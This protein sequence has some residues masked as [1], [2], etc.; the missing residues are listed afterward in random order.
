[1]NDAPEMKAALSLQEKRAFL[2]QRLRDEATRIK[3][4]HPLSYGQRALWFLHQ[5]AQ[6]STAYNVALTMR[7]G[8]RLDISA[9]RTAFETLVARHAA[10]RTTFSEQNGKPVQVIHGYREIYFEEFDASG[11]TEEGLHRRVTEM[12]RRP[13]DLEQGP[14][15]RVSLF[16]HGPKDY[17]LLI[18]AHHI[19]S[20]GWSLWLLMLELLSLYPSQKIGRTLTLPPLP[21]QYQDFV[22]WQAELLAGPEGERLWDYWRQRLSGKLP[23]LHLPTDR[24]R[25][26]MQTNNGAVVTFVLPAILTEELKEQAQ[27]SG[28]TLYMILLAA[29]QVLLHRY[30]GE[31][32]ILVGSP[33]AGRDRGEFEG[34]FGYFVNP[35]ALRANLEGNPTFLAFLDQVRQ[36]A[37]EGLAHQNYPFPL[38]VE[39]LKPVRDANRFPIFQVIFALHKPHQDEE[40]SIFWSG[41]EDEN[42]SVERDGL[43][44]TPFKIV[45]QEGLYDLVVELVEERQLLFGSFKY[46]TDLFKARTITRMA[47]HFRRLLEG[48]VAQ[49][50]MPIAQLPLLT[51]AERQRMLVDWNDTEAPYPRDTCIHELFEE[52]AA[53]RPGAVA[54]VFEDQEV[55]Y[56]EINIRANR[57]AH[58]LRA[59]GVGPE[60]LVGILVEQSVEMVVGLVAILKA[61]G[62]YVPLDPEYPAERLAFMAKDT[63]LAVLLCHEATR[64]RAPKCSA[65]IIELD[66]EL[67]SIAEESPDNPIRL[68]SPDNLAYVIYTS[69]STGKPKG[70]GIEHKNL[71][72]LIAWH[73][74]NFSLTPKDRCTQVASLSFDAAVWEIW[75]VL[76]KGAILYPVSRITASDPSAIK[77]W[78]VSRDITICFLP[79]PLAQIVV[80]EEWS[81]FGSLRFLLTGGDQ[82]K[83]RIPPDLPFH[84]VNNYGP[85]ENTVVTTTGCIE[86]GISLPPIGAPISN[87]RVYLLDAQMNPVPIGVVGELYIGGAGIARGYLGRPELTAEKFIPDPFSDNLDARLYRSGDLCRWLPNGTLEFLDRIDQR[88]KIRGLRIE[89]GEIESVLTEHP[90]IQQA[91]VIVWERHPNDK[92]LVAYYVQ[93][94]EETPAPGKLRHFMEEQLPPY[95]VPAEFVLLKSIPLTPNGKIDRGR[96]PTPDPFQRNVE[97]E[98]IAPR[99]QAE[100]T[101]AGIWNDLLGHENIGIH[102]NFFDLGGHSLLIVQVQARLREHFSPAPNITDIFQYPTIRTLANFLER[103]KDEADDSS[104]KLL[105]SAENRAMRRQ[106]ALTRRRQRNRPASKKQ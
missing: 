59:L 82:F 44:L 14:L 83:T 37:L 76:T 51:D 61:G 56:G 64:G 97:E 67:A 38:L 79:T 98:F 33:S 27:R 74:R 23:V 43:L 22:H 3:T 80:S 8:S 101:L 15:L 84:V 20:D 12:H 72:N 47:G 45:Q 10:L 13:F 50:S 93:E 92:R 36:T 71:A 89:L 18:S 25:P 2:R 11:D 48:I 19:V 96:L 49:P 78:I 102:D 29:F 7:I 60:V 46:N 81:A 85:T 5:G 70:V 54:V 21:W 88:V 87:T 75:P 55:T 9:L 28:A 58:R 105:S 53:K 24:P 100:K 57:L 91:V 106:A 1:M 6:E 86:P 30:T 34:I 95:M 16:R 103:P 77:E 65:S 94:Q 42:A 39:R 4:N 63:G 26:P 17:V 69:G 73:C 31:N 52:Q 40:L 62:A 66:S 104:E 68:A 99:T 90:A 32:D 41:G 35:I